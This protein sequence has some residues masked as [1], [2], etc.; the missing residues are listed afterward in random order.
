MYRKQQHTLC[1]NISIP[2]A[3]ERVLGPSGYLVTLLQQ[4]NKLSSKLLVGF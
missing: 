2:S 1:H 4:L 3:V